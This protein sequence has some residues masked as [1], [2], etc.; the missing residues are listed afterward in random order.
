MP[1]IDYIAKHINVNYEKARQIGANCFVNECLGD[2]ALVDI[3]ISQ[4]IQIGEN[5]R[6]RPQG[7]VERVRNL[8]W[9]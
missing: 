3:A 7:P 1:T 2:D 5:I 8:F 9:S 6:P 4:T